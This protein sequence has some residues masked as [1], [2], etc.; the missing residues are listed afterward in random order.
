MATHASILTLRIPWT[1][2]SSGLSDRVHVP[3]RFRHDSE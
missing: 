3:Q 1:E 2:V